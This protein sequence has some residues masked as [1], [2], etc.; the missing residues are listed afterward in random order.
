MRAKDGQSIIEYV[1]LVA[2]VILALVA[3]ANLG[4]NAFNRHF[5][6]AASE[7]FKGGGTPAK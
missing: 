5:N 2:L 6:A 7:N 3:G 1:L 4:T